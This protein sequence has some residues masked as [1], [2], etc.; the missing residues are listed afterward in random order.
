MN[1]EL[2]IEITR[3][4]WR[5]AKRAQRSRKKPMPLPVCPVYRDAV[6]DERDR[7][8]SSSYHARRLVNGIYVE[9]ARRLPGLVADVWAARTILRAECGKLGDSPSRIARWLWDEGRA[10][11]YSQSSLRPR[12][13][14]AIKI[15]ADLERYGPTPADPPFWRPW[16]HLFDRE[17]ILVNSEAE[18]NG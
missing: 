11:Y 15:I 7:R 1:R 3:E 17:S 8:V 12:V 2:E 16:K 5:L 14:A 6:F 10:N 9:V 4:R 13:H 18:A